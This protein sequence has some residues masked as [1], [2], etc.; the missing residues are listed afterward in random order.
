[1]ASFFEAS[2]IFL[3]AS[4]AEN[5]PCVIL[6]AMASG[7]CVVTTPTSGVTE[8][9]DDGVTG[10]VATGMSGHDLALTLTAALDNAAMR[11]RLGLAAREQVAR[12]L[13]LDLMI[14]RH[15]DLYAE[16]A[17]GRPGVR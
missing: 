16:I 12:S 14:R 8:Q 2:D 1:L 15:L 13:S 3:F 11:R 6:E 7:C 10:L 4:P 17:T 5:F 9:I